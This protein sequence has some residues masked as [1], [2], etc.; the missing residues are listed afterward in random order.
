MRAEIRESLVRTCL[1]PQ[2]ASPG[3]R[4][5]GAGEGCTGKGKSSRGA[6]HSGAGVGVVNRERSGSVHVNEQRD[7]QLFATEYGI[8]G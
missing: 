3:A 1:R 7:V 2:G 6:Q 4:E 5:A 8:A